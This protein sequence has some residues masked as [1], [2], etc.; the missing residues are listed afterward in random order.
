IIN[1]S[2]PYY[3]RRKNSI[4]ITKRVGSKHIFIYNNIIV[5]YN[6][7][8]VFKYRYYINLE[9]YSIV[10]I[11]KYIYKYLYKGINRTIIEFTNPDEIQRYILI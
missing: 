7:Y 4:Y 5:P 6:L 1:S 11:I 2:Y 8:L 10:N 9:I 3:R